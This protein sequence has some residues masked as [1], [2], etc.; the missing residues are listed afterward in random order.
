MLPGTGLLYAATPQQYRATHSNA[1]PGTDIGRCDDRRMSIAYALAG[2][3]EGYCCYRLVQ[4]V[5]LVGCTRSEKGKWY[6]ASRRV[7]PAL[8][9]A[10]EVQDKVRG[11]AG[12]VPRAT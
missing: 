2:T 9:E 6:Y 7:E 11:E 8:R 1:L 12:Q 4:I 5:V 3:A 10:S